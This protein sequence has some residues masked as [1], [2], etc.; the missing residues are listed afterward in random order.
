MRKTPVH[1]VEVYIV[2]LKDSHRT[3]VETARL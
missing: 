3:T 1:L 2:L